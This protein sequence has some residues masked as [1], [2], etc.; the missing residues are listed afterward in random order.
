[1]EERKKTKKQNQ[2]VCTRPRCQGERRYRCSIKALWT[3]WVYGRGRSRV[4]MSH[5]ANTHEHTHTHAR[6]SKHSTP[7]SSAYVWSSRLAKI[8]ES[9]SPH[10]VCRFGKV[11]GFVFSKSLDALEPPPGPHAHLEAVL[12]ALYTW[13][14]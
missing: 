13:G 14:L 1:M 2:K 11:G 10:K 6:S 7:P 3:A 8:P 9:R 4:A 12:A 5:H